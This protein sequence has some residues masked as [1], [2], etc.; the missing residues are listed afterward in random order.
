MVIHRELATLELRPH[1][2][3]AEYGTGS[4]YSTEL[5]A[6]LGALPAR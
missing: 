3:V 4:G 5:I 6:R 2:R 1:M